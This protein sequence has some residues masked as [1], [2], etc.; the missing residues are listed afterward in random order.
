MPICGGNEL[1]ALQEGSDVDVG[2]LWGRVGFSWRIDR[3]RIGG[4]Q[5]EYQIIHVRWFPR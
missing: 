3:T 5:L 2:R 1:E 4:V